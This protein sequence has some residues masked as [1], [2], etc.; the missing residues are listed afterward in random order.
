MVS[1]IEDL[2]SSVFTPGPTPSLVIATNVTFAFLQLLLFVLL[3]TTYSIHFAVLSSLCGGLWWAINWF[4]KEFEIS[5]EPSETANPSRSQTTQQGPIGRPP[6][7]IDTESET[8]TESLAGGEP[9]LPAGTISSSLMGP[10]P[11]RSTGASRGPPPIE[12]EDLKKRRSGPD[13]SGYVSTD[14]EWEKVDE[15]GR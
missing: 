11:P 8:E 3:L 5:R 6:G 15:K 13:N 7:A 4:V 10:P 1:F 9:Q 12:T 14:S 2:W